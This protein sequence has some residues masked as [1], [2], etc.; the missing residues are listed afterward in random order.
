MAIW[1]LIKRLFSGD[2]PATSQDRQAHRHPIP[3]QRPAPPPPSPAAI[4]HRE[5]IIDYRPAIA[6]YVFHARSALNG[7]SLPAQARVTALVDDNLARLAQRRLALVPITTEDWV[8][9]DLRPLLAPCTILLVAPPGQSDDLPQWQAAVG[10]MKAAGARVAL[11]RNALARIPE[12]L[13]LADLVL[14]DFRVGDFDA[15]ERWSKDFMARHPGMDVAVTGIA[16]WAEHRLCQVLGARY[17][18]GDFATR[19]DEAM[20]G[21]PLNQSRMV[22]MELLNLL[23]RESTT[24]E[25]AEVA[26]RDPG[27]VA[28]IVDMANSPLSG[29]REPVAGLEQAL[30]ILGREALYRWIAMGI[31]RSGDSSRDEMLLEIA[32]TRARFLELVARGS[33]A[34]PQCDELFLVGMFSV[35]DSLLGLPLQIVTERIHLPR[36]VVDVLL[37]SEGPYGHYLALTLAMEKGRHEQIARLAER[38]GLSPDMLSNARSETQ[39]WAETALQTS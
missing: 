3:A 38:V 8:A 7:A 5:E 6:G 26:K 19:P 18:I 13:S 12:A 21:D 4:V 15:F 23:R 28:K 39:A 31:F 2:A 34:K 32:L 14:A 24:T 1:S 25:L 20:R 11:D 9:A 22:L 35:F 33:L 30:M 10:Q 16:T 27:V 36:G 17:S 37:H 29:L